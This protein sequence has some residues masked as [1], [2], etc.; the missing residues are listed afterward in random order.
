VAIVSTAIAMRRAR[1]SPNLM[2][3]VHNDFVEISRSADVMQDIAPPMSFGR[4]ISDARKSL[5][6]SQ[7]ELAELVG[8]SP[9]YLNDLERNR[10]N[11]PANLLDQFA[12]NL[13]FPREYLDYVAGQLPPEMRGVVAKPEQVEA[14]FKAFRKT[15]H[16]TKG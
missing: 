9:Q 7:K 4:V 13:G 14:A 15:L 3:V 12:S 10:R 5:G 2:G 8:I 11:P 6:K 1:R 16:A